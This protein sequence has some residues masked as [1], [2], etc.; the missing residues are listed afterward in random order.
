VGEVARIG[1][2]REKTRASQEVH[3]CKRRGAYR[4][5]RNKK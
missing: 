3:R 5:Y 1:D 2:I 4:I